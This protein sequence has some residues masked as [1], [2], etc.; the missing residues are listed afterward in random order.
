MLFSLRR[1][2]GRCCVL[3]SLRYLLGTTLVHRRYAEN[4]DPEPHPSSRQYPS[5]MTAGDG[6]PL[7]A[8]LKIIT[9]DYENQILTA[10]DWAFLQSFIGSNGYGLVYIRTRT[11]DIESSEYEFKV[12]YGIMQRPQGN[13]L[14][15]HRLQD[16]SVDFHLIEVV[17]ATDQYPAVCFAINDTYYL[18][19]YPMIITNTGAASLYT[20]ETLEFSLTPLTSPTA[21]EVYIDCEGDSSKIGIGT[22]SSGSVLGTPCTFSITN[23][24]SALIQVSF[25]PSVTILSGAVN[26]DHYLYTRQL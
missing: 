13:P 9:W 2:R 14:W 21:S 12:Y 4:L 5:T 24:S 6:A 11:E 19:R 22:G 25:Y 23:F 10:E 15:G 20:Y 18:Y 26:T 1:R 16:V 17:T 3:A 8:G 7:P